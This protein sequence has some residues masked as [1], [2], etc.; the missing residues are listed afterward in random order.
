MKKVDFYLRLNI[1][2]IFIFANIW[3]FALNRSF[4]NGMVIALLMFGPAV[5]FWFV[6]NLRSMAV[7]TLYSIF[8]FI[9][10]LVF[11]AEGLELG[12]KA[13]ILKAIFWLPY[14][15]LAGFNSFWALGIYTKKKGQKSF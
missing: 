8:E 10:M 15:V 7:L 4:F 13:T 6:G 5:F 2:F 1:I 9:V 12:G 11:V 14:L 3:D